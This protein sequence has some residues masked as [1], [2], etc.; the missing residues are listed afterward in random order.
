MVLACSVSLRSSAQQ[1]WCHFLHWATSFKS[2]VIVYL[3]TPGLYAPP[4]HPQ[5]SNVSSAINSFT[6]APASGDSA[7]MTL[8]LSA[9]LGVGENLDN[10]L[11]P[12]AHKSVGAYAVFQVLRVVG[13]G[14]WA[15]LCIAARAL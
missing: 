4:F 3:P 2:T 5:A 1:Y 8:L 15:S 10:A 7:T 11:R 12:T 13:R 9:D 6:T 14:V